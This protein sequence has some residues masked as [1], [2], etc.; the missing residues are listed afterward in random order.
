MYYPPSQIVTN[1]YTAGGEF[2]LTGVNY[3]G[4]Y[5]YTSDGKYFT[6]KSPQ[7]QPRRRLSV[8]PQINTE[9]TSPKDKEPIIVQSRYNPY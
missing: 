2:T 5:W 1:Q 7:N 8:N 9:P 3:Q 6:G 4:D